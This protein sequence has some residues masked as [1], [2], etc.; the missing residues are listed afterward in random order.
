MKT[1]K[2][3]D[4]ETQAAFENRITENNSITKNKKFEQID[5]EVIKKHI[6]NFFF[7]SVANSTHRKN[8]LRICR[9]ANF[10]DYKV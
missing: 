6:K 1:S 2:F 8:S 5:D 3:D 9:I 4:V 10:V 7:N